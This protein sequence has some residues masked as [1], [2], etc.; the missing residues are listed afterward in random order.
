MSVSQRLRALLDQRGVKYTVLTHSRAYTA[1]EIAQ[2]IRT[3]GREVAK[4][5]VVRHAGKL[6]LAV[7]PAH[8]RVDLE[9]LGAALRGPVA[10]ASESEFAAAFP[11]CELGAM[12]PFG[13][14]YGFTT[15]LD[16]S[17]TR[18]REIAFN[19]GTHSEAIRMSLD[20]YQRLEAPIVMAFSR[21]P[22]MAKG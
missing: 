8:T 17:L 6:G 16:Q 22:T 1:Q 19:A 3:R 18:D 12:P 5:V 13:A 10:L 7:L 20:D 15:W 11:D 21:D 9:C 2:S 4:V 14:L